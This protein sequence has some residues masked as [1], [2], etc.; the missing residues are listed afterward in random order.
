[1]PPSRFGAKTVCAEL[2]IV[3]VV[4]DAVSEKPV[5]VPLASG[6][7]KGAKPDLEA[8]AAERDDRLT[9]AVDVEDACRAVRQHKIQGDGIAASV[10][11]VDQAGMCEGAGADRAERQS[12]CVPLQVC[13]P[14]TPSD[15]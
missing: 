7:E 11:L 4:P 1:M 8:D 13:L 9:A 12:T 6:W 2:L 15:R 10:L 5:I 14:T 3:Q